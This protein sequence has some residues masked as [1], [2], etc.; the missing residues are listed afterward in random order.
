M[1]DTIAKNLR[2][3]PYNEMM[4]LAQHVSQQLKSAGVRDPVT[5]ELLAGILSHISVPRSEVADKESK[6][7]LKAF[8][9]KR[10]VN[11]KKFNT[12]Y[13][14]EVPTLPGSTVTGTDLRAMFGQMLDQIVTMELMGGGSSRG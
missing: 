2:A 14:I 6:I 8:S 12:G 1:I 5:P 10:Q 13:A 4:H 9:R 11:I 3:M 7:L